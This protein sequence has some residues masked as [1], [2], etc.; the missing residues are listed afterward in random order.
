[1]KVTDNAVINKLIVFVVLA[2]VIITI[3][4]NIY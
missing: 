1:M 2:K 4:A 3:I